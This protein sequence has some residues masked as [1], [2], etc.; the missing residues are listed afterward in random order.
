MPNQIN[1]G[2]L[3]QA[4]LYEALRALFYAVS[5]EDPDALNA[6]WRQ[7]GIV[8]AQTA[9]QASRSDSS[10]ITRNSDR[11]MSLCPSGGAVVRGR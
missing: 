6:A 10:P 9:R 11:V 8:L 3:H 4:K 5:T 1:P 2:E 7:A